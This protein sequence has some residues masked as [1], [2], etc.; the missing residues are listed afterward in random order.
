MPRPRIERVVTVEGLQRSLD[1]VKAMNR[2]LRKKLDKEL[3]DRAGVDYWRKMMCDVVLDFMEERAGERNTKGVM[4][5][6]LWVW[7]NA[8]KSVRGK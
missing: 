7:L 6:E 1:N 5:Y 3:V 8:Q 2:N 4:V